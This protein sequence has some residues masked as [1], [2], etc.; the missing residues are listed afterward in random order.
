[1]PVSA[2]WQKTTSG[3]GTV[4]GLVGTGELGQAQESASLEGG[5]MDH[6]FKSKSK[7]LTLYAT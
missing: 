7:T 2:L 4:T 5:H 1:M 6:L 3:D